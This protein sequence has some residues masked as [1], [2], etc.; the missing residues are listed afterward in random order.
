MASYDDGAVRSVLRAVLRPLAE[1]MISSGITLS[2]AT[3]LLK[4]VLFDAA[5]NRSDGPITDSQVSLLTG[6]HRKD[7][8]RFR[9]AGQGPAR[10]SYANASARLIAL[11]NSD[12]RFLDDDG[13]AVALPRSAETGQ[14][15]DGLVQLLKI[16]LAPGTMLLH[17]TNMGLVK[18]GPDGRL[19]LLAS[20][21]VPLA[22]N[23][24]MLAAFEKNITSH[25]GAAVENL[26]G[27]APRPHFER[28]SHFNRLSAES[29]AAL[30]ALARHLAEEH[31]AKFNAE[32][33]RR[34]RQDMATPS[35]THRIS[36]GSYIVDRDQ[37]EEDKSGQ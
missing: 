22:G 37:A 9:E 27:K 15:F 8:R 36:F 25:L 11:W 1:L 26:T 30:E 16:D 14:S 33:G 17:L 10:A 29:A 23:R 35:S 6:L 24:E 13:K 20:A 3:E 12:P 32:A 7:V 5:R 34:Q 21:Y 19:T 4:Q 18:Q 28:S 2:S 31:L